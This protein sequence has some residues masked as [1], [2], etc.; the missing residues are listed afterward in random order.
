[1]CN[2]YLC[3]LTFIFIKFIFKN[4]IFLEMMP[5]IM[6]SPNIFLNF[7]IKYMNSLQWY[8]KKMDL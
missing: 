2:K 8:F 7:Y 5:N 3:H 4:F 6:V 1:M